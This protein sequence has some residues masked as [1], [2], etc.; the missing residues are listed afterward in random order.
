VSCEACCSWSMSSRAH[1]KL[2]TS[3]FGLSWTISHQSLAAEGPHACADPQ[4]H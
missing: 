2:P 3:R 1:C 4:S